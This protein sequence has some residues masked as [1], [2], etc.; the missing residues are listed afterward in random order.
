[1]APSGESPDF[2][3]NILES[4]R[5]KQHHYR[6]GEHVYDSLGSKR[7]ATLI[8]SLGLYVTEV[9]DTVM[10]ISEEEDREIEQ[11]N[12]STTRLRQPYDSPK[13]LTAE[14]GITYAEIN[15]AA[16]NDNLVAF[17][18]EGSDINAYYRTGFP[19]R[20]NVGRVR[21]TSA[22]QLMNDA[23]F[24]TAST[25]LLVSDTPNFEQKIRQDRD[26]APEKFADEA[27]ETLEALECA[28][29]NIQD[30]SMNFVEVVSGPEG[31]EKA[32][33]KV[34]DIVWGNTGSFMSI[35]EAQHY[36]NTIRTTLEHFQVTK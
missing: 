33:R 31:I 34:I 32:A 14:N 16:I 8:G 2:V 1:M 3:Q 20:L 10:C 4:L 27:Y 6:G 15:D 18:V 7:T 24:Y 17:D 9:V 29:R 36:I 26:A 12:T 11:F 19:G 13:S 22:M 5:E 25:I 23:G 35:P 28:E 30:R 21:T